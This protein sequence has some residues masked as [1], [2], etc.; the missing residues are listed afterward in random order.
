MMKAQSHQLF[1]ENQICGQD[2]DFHRDS[3]QS[4]KWAF[5]ETF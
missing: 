3:L 5:I 1:L 4:P 2:L